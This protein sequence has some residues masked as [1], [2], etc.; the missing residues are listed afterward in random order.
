MKGVI[1]W[2]LWHINLKT[3]A[4]ESSFSEKMLY[5]SDKLSNKEFTMTY[6]KTSKMG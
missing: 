2:T 5:Y 1:L 4:I 3:I 6:Q